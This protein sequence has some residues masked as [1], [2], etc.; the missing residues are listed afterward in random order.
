MKEVFSDQD[1]A[2][3]GFYKSVLEAVGIPNFVRNELG[4]HFTVLPSPV[5]YPALCVVHDGDYDEAVRIL[6][7]FHHPQPSQAAD[8]TCPKCG[9]EV[10]AT[11]DSCWQC[12][13]LRTDSS[14]RPDEPGNA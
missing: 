5:C 6:G 10:P 1:P 13:A 4:N 7:E 9:A 12:G 8:W 3:V 2:R 11:F 14:A